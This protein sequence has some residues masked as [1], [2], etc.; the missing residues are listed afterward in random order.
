VLVEVLRIAGESG[1]VKLG[2]GSTDGTKLQGNASRHK[3]K[4]YGYLKKEVERIRE[5]IAALVTQAY[6]QDVEDDAALASRR[7]DALAAELVCRDD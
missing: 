2:N 1:L 5:G 4:S 7:G 6:Q 3:A